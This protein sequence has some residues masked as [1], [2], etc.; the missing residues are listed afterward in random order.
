M[1]MI[2]DRRIV[3]MLVNTCVRV[4]SGF[5][6]ICDRISNFLRAI[7]ISDHLIKR[8]RESIL[9][10]L[11]K[12]TNGKRAIIFPRQNDEYLIRVPLIHFLQRVLTGTF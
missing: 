8:A 3:R 2:I 6:K 5:R 7:T 9:L 12:S 4:L 11:P 1:A 10:A